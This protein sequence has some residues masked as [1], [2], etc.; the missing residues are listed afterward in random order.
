MVLCVLL[1]AEAEWQIWRGKRTGG[2]RGAVLDSGC[3]GLPTCEQP[4]PIQRVRGLGR[5]DPDTAM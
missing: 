3:R 5:F 2:F 1:W 4:L